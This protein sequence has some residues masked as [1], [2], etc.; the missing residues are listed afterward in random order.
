MAFISYISINMCAWSIFQIITGISHQVL[1]WYLTKCGFLNFQ[2]LKTIRSIIN[3]R[4]RGLSLA[5]WD[6]I[7]RWIQEIQSHV[8]HL[9]PNM[10]WTCEKPGRHTMNFPCFNKLIG[11]AQTSFVS[12]NSV[13]GWAKSQNRRLSKM[14]DDLGWTSKVPAM[15]ECLV[16]Q[17]KLSQFWFLTL[18]ILK[19]ASDWSTRGSFAKLQSFREKKVHQL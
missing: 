16:P 4:Y 15:F 8:L 6:A 9:L 18:V 5:N 2:H 1:W 3:H 17:P 14:L 7:V 13:F 19:C 12:E 10:P 11:N